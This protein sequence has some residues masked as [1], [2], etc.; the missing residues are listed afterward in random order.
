MKK[1]RSKG[2][3]RWGITGEFPLIDSN[4]ITVAINRRRM[5]DRR[6]ENIPLAERLML[7]SQMLPPDPGH[8]H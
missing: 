8:T 3:R 4:G 5:P 6:L 2:Q 7:F 1:R